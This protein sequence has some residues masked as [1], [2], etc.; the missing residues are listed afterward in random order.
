MLLEGN[1]YVEIFNEEYEYIYLLDISFRI[2][3]TYSLIQ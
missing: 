1:V 3:F 2:L